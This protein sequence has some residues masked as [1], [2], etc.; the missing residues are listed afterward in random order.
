MGPAE[1]VII[2][3]LPHF[4]V[5]SDQPSEIAHIG[6]NTMNRALGLQL[7]QS[8]SDLQRVRLLER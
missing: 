7:P 5:A 4:R 3:K 8:R 2:E 1:P 6:K